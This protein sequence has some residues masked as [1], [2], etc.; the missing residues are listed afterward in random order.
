MKQVILILG[1]FCLFVFVGCGQGDKSEQPTKVESKAATESVKEKAEAAVEMAK[2]KTQESVE[3]ANEKTEETA[4]AVKEKAKRVLSETNMS[5]DVI[6][7]IQKALQNAGHDPKYIDGVLGWRTTEAIKAYQ[8]EK[9]LSVGGLS[10]ETIKSLGI[11][12]GG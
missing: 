6:K 12:L 9:G 7:Q 4:K 10:Y 2:E 11:K 5:P 8:K 1:I 3:V